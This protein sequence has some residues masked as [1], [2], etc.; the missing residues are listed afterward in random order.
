MQL[1]VVVVAA[2]ESRV[3]CW[4]KEGWRVLKSVFTPARQGHP[5]TSAVRL[6]FLDRSQGEQEHQDP[7]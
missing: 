3:G 7:I 4:R 2:S 5:I 6:H 1:R